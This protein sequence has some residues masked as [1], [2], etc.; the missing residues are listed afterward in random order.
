MTRPKHPPHRVGFSLDDHLDD[1]TP[2]THVISQDEASLRDSARWIYLQTLARV[3]PRMLRMTAI[4]FDDPALSRW[5]EAWGLVS[6]DPH[7]DWCRAYASATLRAWE[8]YPTS[9]RVWYDRD[10]VEG[11]KVPDDD[12]GPRP[13]AERPRIVPAHV[14]W[15]ARYQTGESYSKIARTRSHRVDVIDRS[16]SWTWPASSDKRVETVRKAC[17]RLA[18]L[19][20]LELRASRR[21]RPTNST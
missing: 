2:W 1:G 6:S 19:L 12:D 13:Q 16:L 17:I 21:G 4:A 11:E 18:A 15:L 10:D 7:D 8:R 5:L 3:H 9:P 14:V 20:R